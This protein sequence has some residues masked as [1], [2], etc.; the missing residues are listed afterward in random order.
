[1]RNVSFDGADD[2]MMIKSNTCKFLFVWLIVPHNFYPLRVSN[3]P[4]VYFLFSFQNHIN[5]CHTLGTR[6]TTRIMSRIA[7]TVGRVAMQY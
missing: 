3:V 7:L 2:S 1:M 6:S 5:R 4:K